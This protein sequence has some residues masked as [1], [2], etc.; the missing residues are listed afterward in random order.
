[1]MEEEQPP[2]EDSNSVET[3][4]DTISIDE[5]EKHLTFERDANTIICGPT[6]SGKTTLMRKI[7][8]EGSFDGQYE[9]IIVCAPT[10]T[11]KSWKKEMAERGEGPKIDYVEGPSKF[12]ELI[13]SNFIPM[14]SVVIL[15]DYTQQADEKKFRVALER[16]FHVTTHHRHLW[17]FFLIHN[18]F[19]SGV[20]SARRNT[21]NFIL[22]NALGDHAAANAFA[23]RLVSAAN[24]ALFM[25]IWKTFA[26]G[27]E[28][29]WMRYD[30]RL[31]SKLHGIV[32][33][34]PGVTIAGG[35]KLVIK[36]NGEPFTL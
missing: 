16:L 3:P 32:S 21:Q 30:Q 23:G 9:R 34:G 14:N 29:G 5:A 36:D 17:T 22:F 6:S 26:T 24:S 20:V 10:E 31:R 1:M 15:D 35:A 19:T 13:E 8:D 25:D 28:R 11:C 33:T 4:P 7:L 27:T 12:I 2:R 18:L